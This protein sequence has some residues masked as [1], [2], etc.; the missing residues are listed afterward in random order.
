MTGRYI[1]S[2][3]LGRITK[4]TQSSIWSSK[5]SGIF[6]DTADQVSDVVTPGTSASVAKAYAYG[7]D[8]GGN[9]TNEQ[10]QVGPDTTFQEPGNG[11]TVSGIPITVTVASY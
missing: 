7:Y 6:Y 4:W 8:A 1:H 11:P 2:L 3:V 5:S 9:R 10:V